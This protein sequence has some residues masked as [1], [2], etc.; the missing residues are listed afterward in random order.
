MARRS[1]TSSRSSVKQL[2]RRMAIVGLISLTISQAPRLCGKLIA[3]SSG[4]GS[5]CDLV[6]QIVHSL[7]GEW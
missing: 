4:P 3:S 1:N 2:L 6:I 7:K 5:T